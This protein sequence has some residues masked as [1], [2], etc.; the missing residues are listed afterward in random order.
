MIPFDPSG[1]GDEI[2]ALVSKAIVR[3]ETAP[4]FEAPASEAPA[5]EAARFTVMHADQLD[6]LPPLQWIRPGE[7]PAHSL[8]VIYGPPGSGKSFVTLDYSLRVAQTQPVLYVAG[9]G[10]VGY[11]ARKMAWCRHHHSGPGQL[12]FIPRAVN[13]L[14][15]ADV[16]GLI[17]ACHGVRAVMIVLDTLARCMV[18]GDENTARDMGLLIAE[19]D[20]VRE[21]T[22]ATI[23]LVHHSGKSGLFERGSSALRAAADQMLELSNDDELLT[24][25]CAKSKDS[26]GFEPRCFR[27]V[28]TATGR[29]D[30]TGEAETSCVLF[31]AENVVSAG[32][33]TPTGRTLLETLSLATFADTGAKSSTL[34]SVLNLKPSTLYKALSA[35]MHDGYVSQ[36]QRGEPYFI[37][38]EG[39][40][41]IKAVL[42]T[43]L[44]LHVER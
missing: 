17:A 12:F 22:R 27:L 25:S 39:R 4:A 26:K 20:R 3:P 14:D 32:E 31:P 1:A 10:A 24:L 6:E 16:D 36:A 23:L 8:T 40:S 15:R 30:E 34:Q 9:E 7:I 37:T 5:S 11:A 38:P 18:G 21:A 33:L 41:A 19:C 29:L 13:L 44:P 35:L 2:A 43:P 42:S 28:T